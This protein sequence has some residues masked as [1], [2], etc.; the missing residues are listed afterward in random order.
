MAVQTVKIPAKHYVGMVKRTHETLP[1][2]FITPWGEDA[3]AQKRIA[4]VDNW[5]KTSYYNEKKLPSMVIDNVPMNGFKMTSDIRSSNYGG[6]D[7]W[8]VED[9]RGFELE[10][11]SGNLAQLLSVGVIDR[12]EILDQCVWARSGQSNVLLSTSTEEY[13]EA[14]VNTAV[15]EMKADWKSVKVGNT[16]LLQN[17]IRGVWLGRQHMLTAKSPYRDDDRTKN[18]LA[19]SD[20]SYHLIYVDEPTTGYLKCQH[21]LLVI[22]SPKLASIESQDTMTE[23]AAEVLSNELLND[24]TCHVDMSSHH[25]VLAFSFG[26]P[27]IGKVTT[28]SL[29][30]VNFEDEAA[31]RTHCEQR[32]SE[33]ALFIKHAG[34]VARLGYGTIDYSNNRKTFTA[35]HYIEDRFNQNELVKHYVIVNGTRS[36]YGSGYTS[37]Q[38]KTSEYV[39]EANDQYYLAKIT[40]KTKSGNTIETH[41]R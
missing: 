36:W 8:R 14:V 25:T 5:A 3:A 9:P 15:S 11:T 19:P 29:E 39:Y 35:T 32:R 12:G 21:Q 28:V 4:T 7:K 13:K 33:K 16:V 22:N 27:Q 41:V 30:Q 6:V 2:G 37:S 24:T 23:A 34:G 20:K 31:L 18:E 17:N 38:P 10:I 26:A 40:L 1:L